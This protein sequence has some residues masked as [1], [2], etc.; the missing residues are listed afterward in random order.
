[1]FRWLHKDGARAHPTFS[2]RDEPLIVEAGGFSDGDAVFIDVL[3]GPP[4]SQDAQWVPLV[5]GGQAILLDKTRTR[6]MFPRS[7]TYRV[8]V[9]AA[10][11]TAISVA[12][13]S[14][15]SSMRGRVA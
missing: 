12:C 13:Y 14:A 7:G 8:R 1:M 9:Q 6:L 10:D 15:V 4:H 2:V 3:A 11:P 5:L